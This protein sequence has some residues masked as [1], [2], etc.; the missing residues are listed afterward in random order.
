MEAT[1]HFHFFEAL[2]L[3]KLSKSYP[4]GW[5]N[6]H[7][8]AI[9]ICVC[10]PNLQDVQW[11]IIKLQLDDWMKPNFSNGA[12][13]WIPFLF[14]SFMFST[15]SS[16]YI[17]VININLIGQIPPSFK[18]PHNFTGWFPIN[19]K[20]EVIQKIC[21]SPA[22]KKSKDTQNLQVVIWLKEAN[23]SNLLLLI[24]KPILTNK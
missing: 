17:G 7:T 3:L 12:Q 15:R 14:S 4:L 1:F 18:C 11:R 23:Q 24:R 13:F 21:K 20:L 8:H 2:N 5:F 22:A 6:V 9:T 10:K 19:L 16:N